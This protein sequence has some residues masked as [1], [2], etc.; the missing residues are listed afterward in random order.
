MWSTDLRVQRVRAKQLPDDSLASFFSISHFLQSNFLQTRAWERK[1]SA[2][3]WENGIRFAKKILSTPVAFTTDLFTQYESINLSGR[4]QIESTS[5]IE[6]CYAF[7][8]RYV[9]MTD[10]DITLVVVFILVTKKRA[11]QKQGGFFFPEHIHQHKN[12]RA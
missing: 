10:T 2:L 5:W 9:Q 6:N 12:C 4:W 7:S 8:R 3:T 1:L 11:E